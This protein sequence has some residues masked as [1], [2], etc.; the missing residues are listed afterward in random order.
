[1]SSV[2]NMNCSGCMNS[3]RKIKC[4]SAAKEKECFFEI[5]RNIPMYVPDDF[6][7]YLCWECTAELYRYSRFKERVTY[8]Y[9]LL[10]SLKDEVSE[11]CKPQSSLSR[12]DLFNVDYDPDKGLKC[13]EVIKVEQHKQKE[14]EIKIED[15]YYSNDEIPLIEMKKKKVTNGHTKVAKKM[16]KKKVANGHT[17]VKNIVE[18]VEIELNAEELQEERKRLQ[19]EEDYVNAMFR[20]EKCIVTFPNSDDLKDHIHLKHDKHAALFKCNICECSFKYNVSF[21]YHMTRHTRRFQCTACSDRFIT[22]STAIHHYNS[23]HC[24][25]TETDIHFEKPLDTVSPEGTEY[26]SK[27]ASFPCE[28]CPKVFQW[29]TSLR[30]HYETHR[31]QN[32]Q[33]RK[34]YCEVCQ[35]SFT[36]SGNLQKHVKCSSK[37]QIQLK[38]RKL[39]ENGEAATPSD[40]SEMARAA[41]RYACPQCGARYQWR[42]NLMRHIRSHQAKAAGALECEPCGRSFSSVATY[43]QHMTISKKHVSEEDFKFMCS[44]CG[45]RFVNRTRL[46]DHIN[47]DHLKNYTHTCNTCQKVFKSHTSLYLHEQVVHRKQ[48]DHL[49]DHCGRPF[50]NQAKLRSHVLAR[51]SGAAAYECADCGARFAWQS[52]LSRHVRRSHKHNAKDATVDTTHAT[53]TLGTHA[54]A[55]EQ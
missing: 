51:H 21:N 37:H 3:D 33:K 7:L 11:N 52:C 43:R 34:P 42:G 2:S 48:P 32:G 49:C 53:V 46:R 54:H 50:P 19:K 36:S 40:R 30:K 44:Q 6:S 4:I 23:V 5:I 14:D 12:Q 31:I 35:L 24:L 27:S 17:E 45:R 10:H 29:R 20:C 1:M 13:F 8:C 22:K 18:C 55:H 16:K 15:D 38:L 25:G 9:K 26:Q 28:F 41:Q 47:W 39:K